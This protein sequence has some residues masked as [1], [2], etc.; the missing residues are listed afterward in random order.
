VSVPSRAV[1]QEGLWTSLKPAT[2][3]VRRTSLEGVLTALLCVT[4]AGLSLVAVARA[5]DGTIVFL[6]QTDTTTLDPGK[7]TDRYS[8][9]V[10]TN[11]Y[12]GLVQ[13]KKDPMNAEPC[14]AERWDVSDD[15]LRWTFHLRKGVKFHNGAP[16]TA[17][18][19]TYTF[20]Q[21]MKRSTEFKN[22]DLLL[23][24]VKEVEEID[25][26][27][28]GVTLQRPHA[29]FLSYLA[30]NCALIV[31]HGSYETP[32][33][34]P[35]GTG[36]F[37][38]SSWEKGASLTI[39]RNGRYW[40]TPPGIDKVVFKIV[41]DSGWMILQIKN[42]NADVMMVNSEKEYE[43][44]VGRKDIGIIR[45]Q[46]SST[47][48][49]AFNTQKPPFDKI[50]VRQALSHLLDKK[51]LVRQVF[52][53]L[54]VP[55]VTPL[56]PQVFGFNAG[57]TDYGYSLPKARE[58]LVR[59]GL[60]RGFSC[61]LM[62]GEGNRGLEEVIN[63]LVI[64]AKQLQIA[65]TKVKLPFSELRARADRGEHDMLAMGWTAALD[66]DNF[67]FPLF[68]RELGNLNRARY[69]NAEVTQLLKA[70]REERN[71]DAR[72]ALYFRVQEIL[73]RDAPWMPLFHMHDVVAYNK[74]IQNLW[75][76]PAR[77]LVFRDARKEKPTS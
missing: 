18:D 42:R 62:Y 22:W 45:A 20:R 7:S 75:W 44:F 59:A 73:H 65:I 14:L 69:Q 10:I 74:Q 48:Y 77:Y 34:K 13:F 32:D 23:S 56:P 12:E 19:V 30:E 63:R 41:A 46:S 49:I 9:E 27:T 6:R 33:F 40:G 55:A 24:P 76:N 53:N 3:A 70:A 8:G 36:P 11:L 67:L 25:D 50:D 66:P 16:L 51:M 31:P 28:V 2:L 54:A 72:K 35:V 57:I 5:D 60:P 61:T 68:T 58:L 52:Q 39:L 17:R 21:R 15:G 43:E 29:P 37:L 38:F 4:L 71:L 1:S 26:L 47:Y 64:N